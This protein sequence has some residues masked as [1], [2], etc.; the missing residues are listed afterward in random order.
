[1]FGKRERDKN[2]NKYS[3]TKMHNFGSV[4]KSV[5]GPY[6]PTVSQFRRI[7]LNMYISLQTKVNNCF[8]CVIVT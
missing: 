6:S 5:N 1:M 2:L 8:F 4:A 3:K 7:P